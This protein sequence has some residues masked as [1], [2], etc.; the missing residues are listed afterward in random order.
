VM[1]MLRTFADRGCQKNLTFFYGNPTWDSIIYRE[2]L[3]DIKNKINLKLV[4]VLERPPEDWQGETGF[5]NKDILQRQLPENY[6]ECT[7]FLC[8]PLPMINAVESALHAIE[9]P[10]RNIHSEQYEMA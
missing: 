10:R 3:A 1:S 2:E 8:G 4:H 5:I 7:F 9:V 6:K